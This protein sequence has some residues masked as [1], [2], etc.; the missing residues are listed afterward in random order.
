MGHNWAYFFKK[1]FIWLFIFLIFTSLFFVIKSFF[2][3]NRMVLKDHSFLKE[4]D[5]I[6]L[7][8]NTIRSKLLY[9]FTNNDNYS[10]VGIL[11]QYNNGL[12]VVHANPDKG[13]VQRDAVIAEHIDDFIKN[14]SPSFLLVLRMKSGDIKL[15]NNVKD[16]ILH[17]LE[18]HTRF[19]HS[20]LLSTDEYLY[21]TELIYKAFRS[22]G[23][24][25]LDGKFDYVDT[26]I[27]T[28]DVVLPESIINSRYFDKVFSL[29]Y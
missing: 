3:Y 6:C 12:F 28:G 18:N 11:I 25:L 14:A 10:H 23:V 24:D 26:P 4:A 22:A 17:H 19:D 27:V 20:F 21:C 5:L 9:A 15:Y 16:F 2:F 7:K 1:P 29:R 13:S 8:G